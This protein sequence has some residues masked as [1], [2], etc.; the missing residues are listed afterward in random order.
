[1]IKRFLNY[2]HCKMIPSKIHKTAMKKH[3]VVRDTFIPDTEPLPKCH[4]IVITT[5]YS[6]KLTERFLFDITSKHNHAY[7]FP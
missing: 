2:L 6:V 7:S 1:M 5:I 3:F 4:N